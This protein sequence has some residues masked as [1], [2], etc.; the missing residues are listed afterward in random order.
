VRGARRVL[1]ASTVV[2][3]AVFALAVPASPAAAPAGPQAVLTEINRVRATRG[4]TTLRHDA[5]L[6]RA[7]RSHVRD[8]MSRDVFE[9]G[10]FE[11][12]MRR[13]GAQGPRFGENIAWGVGSR[14]SARSVVRMWMRSPG[15]R[16]NLLRPGWS[17]VGI[18]VAA[19]SFSGYSGVRL[20]AAA[21]AGD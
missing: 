1:P 6:A 19:G 18:G 5:R 12:R 21:F 13:V 17:R 4:L 3:A 7:S 16:A 8:L 14:G 9:H 10:D 2:L 11:S 20:V 15:H